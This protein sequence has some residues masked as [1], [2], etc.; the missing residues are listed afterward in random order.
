MFFA[1]FYLCGYLCGRGCYLD[2]YIGS[3]LGCYLCRLY[4]LPLPVLGDVGYGHADEVVKENEVVAPVLL[5]YVAHAET[6]RFH[7]FHPLEADKWYNI[8]QFAPICTAV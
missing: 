8:R 2:F 3:Y 1:T 5:H 6:E 7:I 4:R